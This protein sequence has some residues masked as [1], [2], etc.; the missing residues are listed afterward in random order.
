VF[1][2][3]A[4][5]LGAVVLDTRL[6]SKFHG[7]APFEFRMEHVGDAI[8]VDHNGKVGF[9]VSGFIDAFDPEPI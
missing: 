9:D 3:F 2:E 1:T 8:F 4:D 6:L 5:N 7:E